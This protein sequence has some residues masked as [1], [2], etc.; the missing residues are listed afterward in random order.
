MTSPSESPNTL[1]DTTFVGDGE[2]A[3]LM[4]SHDWSNTP[5]GPV[6]NWPQSLRTLVS[7]MLASRFAQV[8]FW[9]ED[10]IQLYNDALIP[11]FG[12]NHPKA[13]G[14][15]PGAI[16]AEVWD[17]QVKPLLEGV[18]TTGEAF[19]A[20]DQLFPLLRFGYLEEVYITF[21][22]SPIWDET[23]KISGIFCTETETTQQVI[24][25]RRLTMLRELATAGAGAK[26]LQSAC[27]AATDA[28]NPYDIPFALFYQVNGGLA[29]RVAECGLSADCLAAPSEI[30]LTERSASW[31][32]V[33]VL[34]SREPLLITDVV[35][36]FGSFP[37]EPW[38]ESPQ[39]AFILPILSSN[40]EAVECLLVAGISPRLQ[41]NPEYR[42]FLELVGQQVESSI[43]TARSYEEERKR[44]EVRCTPLSRQFS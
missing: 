29:E 26:T 39:S 35:D 17:N 30:N 33:D 38:G 1:Y 21:C 13:L 36:R 41:F 7:T 10:Y 19:F 9:G 16:W 4:R 23:G 22:Y 28:L 14:Q 20:E 25:Q 11:T 15:H 3:T 44:A 37:V 43:A 24:G 18:R 32:L 12:A 42:S 31:S 8:V 27:L 6:E 5:L 2:M 40:K 34:Q